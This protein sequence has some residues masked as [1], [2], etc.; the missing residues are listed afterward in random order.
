MPYHY[1]VT[2]TKENKLKIRTK[3]DEGDKNEDDEVH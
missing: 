1:R 2:P 3:K